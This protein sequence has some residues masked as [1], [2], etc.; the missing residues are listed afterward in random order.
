M[1]NDA[2]G[3][4]LVGSST[5]HEWFAAFK[6]GEFNLEG[7][8]SRQQE[9][10]SEYVQALSDGYATQLVLELAYEELFVNDSTILRNF[11]KMVKKFIK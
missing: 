1:T 4:D 11:H 10:E 8:S 5:C 6:K 3:D 2:E 9:F 7:N